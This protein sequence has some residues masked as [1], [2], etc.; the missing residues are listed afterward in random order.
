MKTTP[1][2]LKRIFCIAFVLL[3]SNTSAYSQATPSKERQ[4]KAAFLFNFSQFV[5]W[6]SAAFSD[7]QS[8]LVIGI[9]GD[10]PFGSSLDQLVS[11]EKVNNRPLLIQRYKSVSDIKSCHILFITISNKD[12][13]EETFGKL[14]GRNIL[15]VGDTRNFIRQGG[16]IRFLTENDKIKFQINVETARAEG[17]TISSKLLRLAEIVTPKSN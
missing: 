5:E 12:E 17:I 15:T 13:L 4:L 10:D 2:I 8:P 3:L 9:L 16:M 1:N 11:N 14:K 6:P 7:S